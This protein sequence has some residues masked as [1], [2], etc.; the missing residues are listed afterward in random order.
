M[1]VVEQYDMLEKKNEIPYGFDPIAV[2]VDGTRI[3]NTYRPD[4]WDAEVSDYEIDDTE[5]SVR[6]VTDRM[7]ITVRFKDGRTRVYPL[8][9][10]IDEFRG[11]FSL[12]KGDTDEE[13]MYGDDWAHM[14]NMSNATKIFDAPEL[15]EC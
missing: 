5:G 14:L 8:E 12:Y 4:L 7:K 10:F 3:D 2:F 13:P 11:D 6:F 1:T 9:D 15:I